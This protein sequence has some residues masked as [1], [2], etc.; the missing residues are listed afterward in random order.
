ME[1]D[2]GAYKQ[3]LEGFRAAFQGE[4][5]VVGKGGVVPSG[6]RVI[7]ALGSK[8]AVRGYPPDTVLIYAMAPGLNVTSARHGGP[9]VRVYTVPRPAALL[10]RLREVQPSL[11]S[12]A[13]LWG[14]PGFDSYLRELVQ[15][16]GPL[17]VTVLS[18]SMGGPEDLPGRLR[19]L[20]GKADALWLPPDPLLV[21]A[22]S[23]ETL[24]S[25]SWANDLPYYGSFPGVLEYGAVAMVAV[26]YRSIGQAAAAAARQALDGELRNRVYAEP[27]ELSVS[28]RAAGETGLAVPAEVLK[29]R[30]V[31]P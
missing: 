15:A 21:N 26:D 5:A 1:S 19:A 8:A 7:V 28:G 3:A 27:V 13:V 2:L 17:G 11:R 14:A 22:Q 9:V 20:R 6:A 16:A 23:L 12:V 30:G 31:K 18:E 25:F 4:A 29:A 10:A 24:R